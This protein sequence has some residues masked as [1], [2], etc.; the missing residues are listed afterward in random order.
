MVQGRTMQLISVARQSC[1]TCELKGN[2][3][4]SKADMMNE[5]YDTHASRECMHCQI[6]F[7]AP[8]PVGLW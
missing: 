7:L 8:K 6:T 1:L 5:K 3:K 2:D 4:T